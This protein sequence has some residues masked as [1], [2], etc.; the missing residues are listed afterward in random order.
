MTGKSTFIDYLT[1]MFGKNMNIINP[2]NLK[3]G[4]NY[5]IATSNI[6]AIEEAVVDKSH[7][8]QKIKSLSTQKTIT[9]NIKFIPEFSSPLFPHFIMASNDENLFIRIEDEEIRFFIRKLS[10]PKFKNHNILE[11]VIRE[12][13]AFLHYLTT[14][15]KLSWKESRQL[16]TAKELDN[17]YLRNVK[18]ESKN[19]LYKEMKELFTEFFENTAAT[20]NIMLATPIDIKTKFFNKNNQIQL[21]FIKKTLK[22]DF[23]FLNTDKVIRY[24][25]FYHELEKTGKPYKIALNRFTNNNIIDEDLPF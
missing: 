25:P 19:W 3:S 4:F 16:F 17:N 2:D 24:K 11:D 5:I 7:I 18:E 15:E 22:E 20:D 21:S 12:I 8:V 13:P 1:G 9:V 6:I 23:K 14:L 10:K